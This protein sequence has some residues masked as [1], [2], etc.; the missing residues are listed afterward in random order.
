MGAVSIEQLKQIFAKGIHPPKDYITLIDTLK[1]LGG[2]GS[3]VYNEVWDSVVKADKTRNFTTMQTMSGDSTL[4][5]DLTGAVNGKGE[6]RGF[7]GDGNKIILSDADFTVAEI[8]TSVGQ[9]VWVTFVYNEGI[10]KVLVDSFNGELAST[11]VMRDLFA[12]TTIDTAKWDITDNADNIDI[13]QDDGALFTI[14]AGTADKNDNVWLSKDTLDLS[15]GLQGACTFEIDTISSSTNIMVEIWFAAFTFAQVI[16]AADKTKGRLIVSGGEY[17]F[18]T[19]TNIVGRW[20][21]ATYSN[22]TLKFFKW[23]TDAWVQQGATVATTK[24]RADSKAQIRCGDG[25]STTSTV[26]ITDVIMTTAPYTT[27]FPV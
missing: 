14:S 7:H 21:I 20:Q 6:V 5:L 8:Q 25:T 12:G 23:I 1:D 4:T 27:E 24:G 11:I 3:V 17:D 10:E 26:K 18:T 13:T 22:Q 2:G 9:D 16:S 19:T 15:S